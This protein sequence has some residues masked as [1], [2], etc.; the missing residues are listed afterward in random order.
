MAN[1]FKL[2]VGFL[3]LIAIF[4][5]LSFFNS[6]SPSSPV[7]KTAN[8]LKNSMSFEV[9]SDTDKDGLTNRDE[10]YWNTDFQNPDSD[11]DGFLDGEEVASGH[12]PLIPGPNDFLNNKNLTDKL[13]KLT[14]SGL[15]EGSLKP[16]SPIYNRS[17]NDVAL[18]V[19]DDASNNLSSKI[20][21][22]N[23]KMVSSSKENQETYL[24]EL[25]ALY[26]EFILNFGEEVKNIQNYLEII[27]SDGFEN[28][29]LINFFQKRESGFEQ[30]FEK[31]YLI[32]IPQNW[33][34]DH[35]NFLRIVKNLQLA[36]RSI[37]RGSEDPV[38]ASFALN[39]LGDSFEDLSILIDTFTAKI[40]SEK[41][42]N[43]FFKSLSQ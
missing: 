33:I 10:S 26:T 3:A 34:Q 32:N 13:S 17:L 8:I 7:T 39:I 29:E 2:F 37:A 35:A 25:S 24:K 19:I 27:N 14:L 43:Q 30:T 36:N 4:S 5:V 9:D 40:K 20:D 18:A 42:S 21:L 38:K 22:R 1:K 12:D 28:K 16:D 41:L 23:F 11:G 6:F 15:Y 31:S